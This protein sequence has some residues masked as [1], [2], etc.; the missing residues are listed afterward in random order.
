VITSAAA[1]DPADLSRRGWEEV[2]PLETDIV[3]SQDK[4]IH[5]P[6]PLDGTSAGFMKI[7]DPDLLLEAWKP[8]EDGNGTILRL[9][10]LAGATRPVSVE[11]PR[12]R[13]QEVWHT[14]A[15]E[16]DQ[17]QLRLSGQRGFLLT[18]H[19]H[20]IVTMRILAKEPAR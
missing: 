12:M 19:P 4:A 6:E 11:F 20:E 14:D 5:V 18:I 3:T 15:V 16:R 9:L 13:L 17:E 7:D 8:A 1:I 10:N 2:T